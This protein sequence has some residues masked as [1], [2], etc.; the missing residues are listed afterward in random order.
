MPNEVD[1]SPTLGAASCR[2][3]NATH[4]IL[5]K[6]FGPALRVSL[7]VL[8]PTRSLPLARSQKY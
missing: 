2:I 4:T 7:H 8:A 1:L 3:E 5:V 6:R